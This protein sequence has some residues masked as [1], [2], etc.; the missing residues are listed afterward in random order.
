MPNNSTKLALGKIKI[1]G[2]SPLLDQLSKTCI[3]TAIT[4]DEPLS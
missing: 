2:F 1:N 4:S 3:N